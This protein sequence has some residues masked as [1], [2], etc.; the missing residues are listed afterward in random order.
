MLIDVDRI[1][2]LRRIANDDRNFL[3]PY[4]AAAFDDLESAIDELRLAIGSNDVRGARD[5]LHKI[6]GTGASIGA[7]ALLASA[8]NMRNYITVAPTRTW[9]RRW[10][11][12]PRLALLPSQRL[13]LSAGREAANRPE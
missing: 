9:R 1:D 6:D 11:K 10:R 8:K 4:V 3:K 5:A 7:V 13:L 2:A 12:S